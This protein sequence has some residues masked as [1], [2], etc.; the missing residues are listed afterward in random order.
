MAIVATVGGRGGRR[1]GPCCRCPRRVRPRPAPRRTTTVRST[2]RAKVSYQNRNWTAKW[3]TQYEAPSTGGIGLW[4]GQRR[5]RRH[6][7][8]RRAR[9][10][11]TRT[12]GGHVLSGRFDR[13]LPNGNYYRAKHGEPGY[14]PIISTWSGAVLLLRPVA[15][16]PTT[17]PPAAATRA[18]SR[19]SEAQSSRDVPAAHP[20]LLVRRHGRRRP[21]RSG[22][23]APPAP[24]GRRREEGVRPRRSWHNIDH[25]SGQ[26]RYVEERETRPTGRS[27]G[28]RSQPYGCPAASPRTTTAA[29]P[30]S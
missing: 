20:V 7:R 28:D 14:D 30:I 24:R 1:G 5:L 19:V 29:V 27:T 23:F 16:A 3:W 2:R 25:E 17:P 26:L 8:W 15:A 18:A 4:A 21:A 13:P 10:A 6:R 9:P 12:G 11:T 22:R